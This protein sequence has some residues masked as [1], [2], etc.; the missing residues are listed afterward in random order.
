[1]E[2]QRTGGFLVEID[3][4]GLAVLLD[5]LGGLL[6]GGENG[7]L[8]VIGDLATKTLLVTHLALETPDL[9]K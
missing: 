7:L 2:S 5:P 3:G 8:V 6:E 9:R 1:M 4:S